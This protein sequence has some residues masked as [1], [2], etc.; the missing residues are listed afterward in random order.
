M[1]L[2]AAT[3]ERFRAGD[4]EAFAVLVRALGPLVR[5]IVAG[6][7][8]GAFDREEAMQEVWMQLF[9]KREALDPARAEEVSGW[10]AVV[11]RH[12]CLDLLRRA[13]HERVAAEP[14][15]EGVGPQPMEAEQT[16]AAEARELSSAVVAFEAKLSGHWRDFFRLHFVEGLPYEEIAERLAISRL[17]CKYLK[18]VLAARARKNVTLL[19]AL[20]RYLRAGGDLAP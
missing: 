13:P 11:T 6:Y 19:A 14:L 12:R 1:T 3:L 2:P 5:S 9:E 16:A 15:D 18:K 4:P 7:F 8:R 17:R 10:V 20:G